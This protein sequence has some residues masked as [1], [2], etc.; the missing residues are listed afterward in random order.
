MFRETPW[1]DDF[2]WSRASLLSTIRQSRDCMAMLFGFPYLI[3][4]PITN[5]LSYLI[6]SGGIY[7]NLSLSIARAL[8]HNYNH[9]PNPADCYQ[10]CATYGSVNQRSYTERA[11]HFG[12]F[13]IPENIVGPI[14]T[15]NFI[16][17]P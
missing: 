1:P 15:L 14:T 11:R 6:Y 16:T 13:F 4:V 9:S 8:S 10:R 3:R 17:S 2:I 5:L 7:F 12:L